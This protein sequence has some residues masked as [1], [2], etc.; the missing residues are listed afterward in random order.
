V[1]SAEIGE[2]PAALENIKLEGTFGL[3]IGLAVMMI[4]DVTLG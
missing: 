1:R 2:R 4:P 3:M